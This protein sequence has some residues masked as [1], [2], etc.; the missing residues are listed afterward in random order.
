MGPYNLLADQIMISGTTALGYP[1]VPRS[2][3]GGVIFLVS[4]MGPS[5]KGVPYARGCLPWC[6]MGDAHN[7]F[8]VKILTS[9]GLPTGLIE[10]SF[11]AF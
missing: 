3:L 8:C 10:T 11:L 6:T 1:Q 7:S 2:K 5:E 9:F 4:I